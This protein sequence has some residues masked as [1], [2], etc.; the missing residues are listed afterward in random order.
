MC[1]LYLKSALDDGVI[2]SVFV[3]LNSSFLS[4]K[5][6]AGNLFTPLIF[7]GDFCG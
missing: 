4:E 2:L 5:L 3:I 1:E 7:T 6:E